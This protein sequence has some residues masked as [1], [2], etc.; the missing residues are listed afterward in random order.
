MEAEATAIAARRRE[1]CKITSCTTVDG[2]AAEKRRTGDAP[3]F[4]SGTSLGKD[5]ARTTGA[6]GFFRGAPAPGTGR[7][8]H[9][10]QGHAGAQRTCNPHPHAT[11]PQHT[12]PMYP[13]DTQE[14]DRQHSLSPAVTLPPRRS[15]RLGMLLLLLAVDVV[16]DTA[17]GPAG[18]FL[19]SGD[20][21]ARGTAPKTQQPTSPDRKHQHT[22]GKT[23]HRRD[24]TGMA[25][26]ASGPYLQPA[27]APNAG[28]PQA[29]QCPASTPPTQQAQHDP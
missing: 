12:G 6:A 29:A 23:R 20:F 25:G 26:E 9:A 18:A 13:Q 27:L 8:V 14:H 15:R 4:R 16:L 24:T 11:H 5:E 17:P 22:G 19:V 1:Q 7:Q 3:L 21:T 10:H 28:P 2:A